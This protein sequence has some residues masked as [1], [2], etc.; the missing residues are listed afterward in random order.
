[1]PQES[2]LTQPLHSL[3]QSQR[4]ASLGTI[5]DEGSALVSM[6]PFTLEPE[7]G[8]LVIHVS[9]LAAHTRNLQHRPRVSLL[10]MQAEVPGQPVH[11]L[12]RVTFEGVARVLQPDTQSWQQCRAAYL[13]RF[14]DVDFMTQFPDFKFVAID[15]TAARQVAGFGAARSIDGEE[16]RQILGPGRQGRTS[17]T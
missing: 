2:R 14:P 8:C 4:V 3:L 5:T 16:L 7:L 6:V 12:P 1:M 15:I 9:E 10:V 17:P 13:Q 11:A